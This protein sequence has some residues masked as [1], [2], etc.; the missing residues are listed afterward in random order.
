MWPL[1]TGERGHY[2]ML[3][4]NS[5]Q[6]FLTAM[7]AMA[8][9]NGMLPEQV[10][11]VDL[12]EAGGRMSGTPTGSAMPL[13]WAHAEFIKLLLSSQ[14]GRAFDCPIDVIERYKGEVAQPTTSVW[15]KNAP[16]RTFLAGSD[17]RINLL[18]A[19]S[20]RWRPRGNSDWRVLATHCELTGIHSVKLPTASL[21]V[22]SRVAFTWTL[23][24][25]KD[26]SEPFEMT[27]VKSLLPD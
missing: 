19:A 26:A 3:A 4:G 17:L 22:G 23:S 5:A 18:D 10:W 25:S 15:S 8:G 16:S 11:D 2:E 7:C 24:E 14:L 27:A 9:G 12:D 20:V 13:A 1:L 6:P 21:P